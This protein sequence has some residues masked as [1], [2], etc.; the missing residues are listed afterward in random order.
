MRGFNPKP[1][2]LTEA[3]YILFI[4]S[5]MPATATFYVKSSD[6]GAT[7]STPLRVNSQ[8]GAAIA[9]GTIRGGQIAIGKNGRVHV[10]WNGS[11]QAESQGPLNPES[12][13]R[14]APMFYSRLDDARNA[15]SQNGTS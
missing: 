2:W 9:A 8:P 14:G 10:A 11:S 5:V 7:W 3:L 6:A 13:K 12:G 15:F 4:T 1:S